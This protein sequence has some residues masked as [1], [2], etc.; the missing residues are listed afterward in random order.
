MTGSEG[1]QEQNK[2]LGFMDRLAVRRITEMEHAFTIEVYGAF[3]GLPGPPCMVAFELLPYLEEE[4]FEMIGHNP[5][6]DDCIP[7][8]TLT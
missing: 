6:L 4:L 7:Y 1:L 3:F 5:K 8:R 2:K